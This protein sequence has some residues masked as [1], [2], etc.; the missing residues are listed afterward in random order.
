MST[1][2]VPKRNVILLGIMV[3]ALVLRLRGISAFPLF[4]DEMASYY[5][6]VGLWFSGRF[7][8]GVLARPLYMLLMNPV[9]LWFPH[10]PEVW[11]GIAIAVSLW[12][13][14]LTWLLAEEWFGPG[15]GP[16]AALLA[17]ISPLYIYLSAFARYWSLTYALV[18]WSALTLWRAFRADERRAYLVALVPLV[19]GTLT[20][21]TFA[22][23]IAGLGLALVIVN[24]DGRIGLRLP[25]RRAWLFL[26]LPFIAI[27]G[28]WSAVLMLI[29]QAS[30]IYNGPPPTARQV[31]RLVPTWI[32][33]VGPVLLV[34]AGAGCVLS[35][36]GR[37]RAAGLSVLI[38]LGVG[39]GLY[40]AGAFFTELWSHYIGVFLPLIFAAAAAAVTPPVSSRRVPAAW[41]ALALLVASMGPQL[42]SHLSDGTRWDNRPLYARIEEEAPR[43]LLVTYPGVIAEYYAPT[44]KVT[45]FR[46]PAAMDSL[47]KGRGSVWAI[48]WRQRNRIGQDPTGGLGDWLSRRCTLAASVERP[49]FDF[50]LYRSELYDCRWSSPEMAG[51]N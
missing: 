22:F 5:E 13:I 45:Q 27:A 47:L 16:V 38:A 24:P 49:R 4:E 44:L 37:R 23:P 25:T 33:F 17:A 36:R 14:Y 12:G 46:P 2:G 40:L 1:G 50:R 11:R 19:L 41:L 29:D 39:A 42:L 34:A 48:V 26:I 35:M 10:T 28:G 9:M 32:E 8:Q 6:S 18:A 3:L 15:S 43:R 51:G 20:H 30:G 31:L 21:P 7:S